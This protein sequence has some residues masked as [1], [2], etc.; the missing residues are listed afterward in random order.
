MP[1]SA[2]DLWS[3]N[4]APRGPPPGLGSTKTTSG[5]GSGSSSNWMGLIGRNSGTS[6]SGNWQSGGG[7]GW[8]SPWL[9]LKNLTAQVTFVYFQIFI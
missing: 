8:F 1:S 3:N 5:N 9:L 4:K 7:S 6:G 2:A